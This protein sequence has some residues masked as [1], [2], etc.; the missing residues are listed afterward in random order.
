M[1]VRAGR[2]FTASVLG[3][4]S[5]GGGQGLQMW[6]VVCQG[7]LLPRTRTDSQHRTPPEARRLGP[8]TA[9]EPRL[10]PF[11]TGPRLL[12]AVT[13]HPHPACGAEPRDMAISRAATSGLSTEPWEH[14]S[15]LG[16]RL[17]CGAGTK[18]SNDLGQPE[19]R[20][21]VGGIMICLRIAQKMLRALLWGICC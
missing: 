13:P 18:L 7:H 20:A 4:H 14:T 2:H 11:L 15:P 5:K 8:G 9:L 10:R 19:R 6:E 12:A 1:D 16:A 21:G 3:P 17:L